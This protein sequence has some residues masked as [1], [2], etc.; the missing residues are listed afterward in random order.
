[1]SKTD[2]LSTESA[3]LKFGN[4]LE[5]PILYEGFLSEVLEQSRV[6]RQ[7]ELLKCAK[8]KHAEFFKVGAAEV[9]YIG[10]HSDTETIQL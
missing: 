9:G 5:D 10:N 2:G 3:L 4:V 7:P 1:M 8:G 6:D